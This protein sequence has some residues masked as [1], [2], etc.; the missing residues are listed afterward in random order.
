M[1]DTATPET[2]AP[3]AP[4]APGFTVQL[5]KLT[6]RSTKYGFRIFDAAGLLCVE[7]R[8]QPFVP[9]NKQMTEAGATAAAETILALLTGG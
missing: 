2:P 5:F 1:T 7:Q 4:A 3:E 9:G 6:P 8:V